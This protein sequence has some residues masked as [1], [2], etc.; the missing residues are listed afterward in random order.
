MAEIPMTSNG[1]MTPPMQRLPSETD[2]SPSTS[3]ING[4]QTDLDNLID[5]NY[6]GSLQHM[7]SQ[8]VGRRVIV[9]FLVGT[10]NLIRKE[11]ILYLVGISYIVL[12]DDKSNIYTVCNLYSIEFVSFIPNLPNTTQVS[13][14]T[15]LKR[16]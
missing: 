1:G 13:K 6:N 8:N 9:D 3:N 16:V 11:G 5:Q 12:F 7:L 14:A 15:T 4:N 2:P 10:S